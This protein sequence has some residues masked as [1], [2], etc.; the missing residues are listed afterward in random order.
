MAIIHSLDEAHVQ[1]RVY[2]DDFLAD[3][4]GASEDEIYSDM[5]SVVAIQCD[6]VIAEKFCIETIG[7]VP[8]D[9]GS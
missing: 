2:L 4:P 7:W 5:V 3:Q 1:L 9:I 6:P 8:A